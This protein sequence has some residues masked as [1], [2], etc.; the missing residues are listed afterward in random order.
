MNLESKMV[1]I[2]R[3]Y[4]ELE[5]LLSDP[6]VLS[7]QKLVKKY[8]KS[9]ADLEEQVNTYHQLLEIRKN[10][11]DTK[12]MLKNENEP[13]MRELI[14]Q[15]ILELEKKQKELE[16]KLE[17]LLLPKDPNDDKNII[18]EIRAGTGGEEASLFAGDLMRMY[19]K[20][21]EKNGWKVKLVDANDTGLGGYKEV[22]MSISGDKVYSKLKYEAG[23]HRVQRVPITESSGRIHTSA[24]TVAVIPEAEEIELYIDPK[25]LEISTMR[26]G[27][28]GGQ[29]VN[30][31]ETAVR[32]FHKPSG[33]M[34][35]CSEER[36]Q[37]QNKEKA[38]EILRAKL[39][40]QIMQEQHQAQAEMK[41]AMVGSGDRSERIRTFN[42]PEN[43][44]TDHRIKL[45]LY[46]LNEI[47]EGDLDEIIDALIADDQKKKLQELTEIGVI[48]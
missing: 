31:V 34:V 21:A 47:L 17:I 25:D 30:K 40:N 28:A 18:M 3:T 1:E 6:K 12:D 38:M 37:L 41:S 20:Y 35:A 14:E 32:I 19:M 36:S 48:A 10:L 2:E 5:E 13:E 24:A 23:V 29:N 9:R 33:I 8:S 15:E 39:W 44:V 26:S 16:E 46:K 27:G 22:I 42:F 43:R 11:D 45:T 7:D 4:K